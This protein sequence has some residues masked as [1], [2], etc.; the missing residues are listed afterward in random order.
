MAIN[1]IYD[2]YN[3]VL[4][5]DKPLVDQCMAE[6]KTQIETIT[7]ADEPYTFQYDLDVKLPESTI[8][9]KQR[10]R[11]QLI[12]QLRCI[13]IRCTGDYFLLTI[14]WFVR[15]DREFMKAYY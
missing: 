9:Q 3:S 14:T 5:A 8:Q 6:I 11:D 4:Q 7:A 2:I 15:N 1:N 13:G 10:I 12:Y